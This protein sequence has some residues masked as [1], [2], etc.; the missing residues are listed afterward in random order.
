MLLM[1]RLSFPPPLPLLLLLLL[2]ALPGRRLLTTVGLRAVSRTSAMT[3]P[4][5]CD[6]AAN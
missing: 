2:L 6:A 1:W 3:G 4:V 5:C